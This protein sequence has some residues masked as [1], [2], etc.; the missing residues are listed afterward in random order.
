MKTKSKG[1]TFNTTDSKVHKET[2]H[3]QKKSPYEQM[4]TTCNSNNLTPE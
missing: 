4:L 2:L 1:T 3:I